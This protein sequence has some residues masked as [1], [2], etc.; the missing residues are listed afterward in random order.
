M[1]PYWS[2]VIIG[3]MFATNEHQYF[4]TGI[5][6]YK[7]YDNS[8]NEMLHMR[9]SKTIYPLFFQCESRLKRQFLYSAIIVFASLDYF[10]TDS[11][12]IYSYF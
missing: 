9:I 3:H 4:G 10:L 2:Y 7:L 11:A 12:Q 5:I 8:I 6:K 1:M